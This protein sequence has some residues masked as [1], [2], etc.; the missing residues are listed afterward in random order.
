MVVRVHPRSVPYSR[1]ASSPAADGLRSGDIHLRLPV[2]QA[3]PDADD[4]L[5][6]DRRVANSSRTPHPLSFTV[7]M[8]LLTWNAV[9]AAGVHRP[10]RCA[11]LLLHSHV[12]VLNVHS[13]GMIQAVTN[14]QVGLK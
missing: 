3:L 12:H 13:L 2:H 10:S 8:F 4:D 6:A 11:T 14:R 5:G 7:M 1:H 9:A